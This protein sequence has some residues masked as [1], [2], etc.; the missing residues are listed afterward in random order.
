VQVALLHQVFLQP[1]L[2]ALAEE[3]AVRQHHGGAAT[4]LEQ[5][6]DEGKKEICGLAGL[7]VPGEVRFDAVLLAPAE[8]RIGENDIDA[9]GLAVADVGAR[10]R[11]VVPDERRAAACW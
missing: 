11:V 4:G 1:R 8:G 2:D 7:E 5:A 6:D 10:E 9:V 3:R